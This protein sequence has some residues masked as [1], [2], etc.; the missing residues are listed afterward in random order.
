MIADIAKRKPD[1]IID[2][3]L[4]DSRRL[5][6]EYK[7]PFY[8]FGVEAV[9]FQY[10]FAEIMRQRSAECGEYLPIEEINSV[11]NKD[12]RIQS[13]QPFVKNGYIKFSKKHKTLIDQMLKYPMGKN[14]DAPDALQ[15]AVALALSVKVGRKVDYKSVQGRAVRFRRG[16]Y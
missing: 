10:Y 11:Q 4:D 13:L 7:K 1:K 12:A 6:R 5:R 2:D 8:K 15:M 16:A 9:Q 14:D 3:A